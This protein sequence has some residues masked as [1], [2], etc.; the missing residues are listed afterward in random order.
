[1]EPLLLAIGTF[2]STLAGGLFGIRNRA[3]IHLVISFTAGVLVGIVFFD[4]LPE[5]FR[6]IRESGLSVT[7]PMVALIVGFLAIHTVEK[8]T[9]I[10]TAHENK[11]ADH[12]HPLVGYIGASG[13]ALHSLLD[14]M[15]IGLGFHISPRMGLLIAI[16]VI[17]HDF[18]DGLNT[19]S[20]M[21]INK[22][23]VR[24]S[25]GFLVLDA[26]TPLVGLGATYL[27]SIPESLL[28]IYLGFFA[29]FLLYIGAGDL[30]PEAHSTD[31][32]YKKIGLTVLGVAFIFIV[33][34][35]T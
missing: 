31:S 29:G 23:N 20:L 4:V 9:V 11:Y 2:L 14:G 22:N 18:S 24:K 21:L 27:F 15:G 17:T 3:R 32:S 33:T 7:R 28:V 34:R 8:L 1:M 35:F 6:I 16:A 5:V 25:L 13:L 12:K 10:H 26:V 30:L 19:V